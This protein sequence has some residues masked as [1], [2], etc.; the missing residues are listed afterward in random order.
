M[1]L[2]RIYGNDNR[3]H[4]YTQYLIHD[5]QLKEFSRIEFLIVNVE[6]QGLISDTETYLLVIN[7][8]LQ[9]EQRIYEIIALF[10]QLPEI[11][12]EWVFIAT[13]DFM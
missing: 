6:L 9:N 13:N 8:L 7:F 10:T 3:R 1:Y 5:S 2:Y 4:K 11:W 12:N